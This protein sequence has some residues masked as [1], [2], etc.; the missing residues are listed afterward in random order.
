MT[1]SPTGCTLSEAEEF[2]AAHPEIEAVDLVLTDAN[3]IG[4]GKIIRRHELPGAY[5]EG[6]NL[7]CSILGLDVCGDD[8]HETG[9]TWER[10]D[11]DQRAWPIPGTLKPIAGT[12]PP[13]A[14]LLMSVFEQDGRPAGAD[15]RLSLVRQLDRLTAR[16]LKA[17]GAFELEFFLFNAEPGPDGRPV[18]ARGLT[19][20]RPGHG[21]Q[22]YTVDELN[23]MEPLFSDIYAMAAAQDIPLETMISEFAAGQYELT[24]HY[25]NDVLRAADDL[26]M[27]KGIVRHA[28]RRHGLAACFMA[29]PF[30]DKTGSGMHFHVSVWDRDGNIFTEKPGEKW[31]PALLH[32]MGGLAATMPES[33]LVFAPHANSWR[34]FAS[35]SYAPIS[36]SWGVNNRSVALRVPAS[37]P[38]ARRIEHRPTGVDANP[39]LVAAT[40]IAGILKGLDEK[41]DPGP[42][43]TGNGYEAA[44]N[45]AMPRD[46][47]SAIDAARESAFLKDALGEAMHHAFCAIKQAEQLRVAS[48]VPD[49][50]YALYLHAV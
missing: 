5:Q 28:A 14:Q 23:L 19:G 29:K 18:P 39:Y 42:E 24:L 7:P 21:T 10:G 37:G 49:I 12:T 6:R 3:G 22:V 46:W 11:E 20:G 15:P 16:G 25:R 34:R 38:K 44:P 33:M 31:S 27:L 4:R 43:V 2:L 26:I 9:L 32:A 1:L 30:G 17:A 8:V 13:R 48:T 35:A 41:L 47:R 36:T 40:I 50:D 45:P